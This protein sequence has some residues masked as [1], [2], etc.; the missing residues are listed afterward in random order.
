MNSSKTVLVVDDH[1][2]IRRLA[3]LALRKSGYKVI[4]ACD[5]EEGLALIHSQSP[6]VVITD[7]NMPRLD[8]VE[9]CRQSDVIKTERSFLTVVVTARIA[10]GENIWIEGLRD[11]VL[12]EKP[13]SPINMIQIVNEYLSEARDE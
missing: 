2:H 5:G 1:V 11:T 3:E 13:F 12:M 4:L 6:D 7:I 9:L 10:A 8:G